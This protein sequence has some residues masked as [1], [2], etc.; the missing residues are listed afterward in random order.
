MR[1]QQPGEAVRPQSKHDFIDQCHGHVLRDRVK[2]SNLEKLG[3]GLPSPR[4]SLRD[5]MGMQRHQ[6]G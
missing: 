6:T 2:P 5:L 3:T 4:A 1:K